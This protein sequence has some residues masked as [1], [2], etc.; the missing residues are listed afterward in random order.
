MGYRPR[1]RSSKKVSRENRKNFQ[2]KKQDN[3]RLDRRGIKQS[4]EE[5]T[6]TSHQQIFE[7]TLKRLHTLGNQKFGSSPFSEHFDRWML[8]VETVLC[9]F[10][11]Q[12]D[13]NVDEQFTKE[14]DQAVT[15]IKL[16]LESRRQQE[17]S[18]EMQI[19]DVSGAKNR[20][21]QT[22]KEY[23]TKALM[24]KSQK[25]VA[26]K[27]LNKE[28]ETLKEE[29]DQI[30]KIK[31]GFFR[32]ITKKERE[33]REALIVQRYSDKQQEIEV[34]TLNFKEEQK[35]LREE[36][37][38]KC[39]PLFEAVKVSQKC[40]KESDEDMSL[41]ERWF[42]CEVLSDAINDFLQRKISKL[43]PS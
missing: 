31:T 11:A 3:K 23:L 17:N 38:N 10:E 34:T 43:P 39:V 13:V 20:L 32:G 2:K 37:E 40:T 15:T 7:I 24:L 27:R 25:I 6:T 9:E 29:Q 8:N 42:A 28:M 41:E 1:T 16:Q 5:K 33:Q 18:I 36:Y 12:P 22:K 26:L 21:Q 35:Q 30:V 19:T 14:R 4:W